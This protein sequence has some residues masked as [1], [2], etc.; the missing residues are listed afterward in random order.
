[1]FIS[2]QD[3][4]TKMTKND[5]MNEDAIS[6]VDQQEI[7][8]GYGYDS[9]T[10]S[11]LYD[12]D[13]LKD[14]DWDPT[15]HTNIPES[16]GGWTT[17]YGKKGTGEKRNTHILESTSAVMSRT[18]AHPTRLAAS[19]NAYLEDLGLLDDT[20]KF[21]PKKL[22]AAREKFG[23][24]RMAKNKS[25]LMESGIRGLYWDERKDKTTVREQVETTVRYEGKK[26]TV[27]TV[28]QKQMVHEHCPVLAV[29][30]KIRRI[31]SPYLEKGTAEYLSTVLHE[32][33]KE[34]ESVE[35][36]QIVG[37]DSCNKMSGVDGGTQ[38]LLKQKFGRPLQRIFCILHILE[39]VWKRFFKMVDGES[40]SPT[41]LTGT[42]GKTLNNP[43]LRFEDIKD[44]EPVQVDKEFFTLPERVV[45]GLSY[46][47]KICYHLMQAAIHGPAYFDKHPWLRTAALGKFHE[48]HWVTLLNALLRKFFSTIR[49]KAEKS[50]N[51]KS[52]VRFGVIVYGTA[53]FDALKH[54]SLVEAAP[55]FH[56]LVVSIREFD[57]FKGDQREK[58][59]KVVDWNSYW[60]HPENVLVAMQHDDREEVRRRAFTIVKDL[61]IRARRSTKV[62]QFQKIEVDWSVEH[63][64]DFLSCVDERMWTCPPVFLDVAE[65]VLRAGVTE[66][67]SA[68][69]FDLR[70][71]PNATRCVERAVQTNTLAAA[72]TQTD[73]H[74]EEV[75][76][77]LEF[78]REKMPDFRKKADWIPHKVD[79]V[80]H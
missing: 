68:D 44:F 50:A 19:I 46:D 74:R 32:I 39:T 35:K 9:L 21:G 30:P 67:P 76:A 69:V 48:A 78:S 15:E 31:K 41:S 20:T 4:N 55:V 51:L 10:R 8:S 26:S 6:V 33:C 14:L 37:S 54:G 75:L 45:N 47:Q 25:E 53:W 71:Y 16:E 7:E 56:R 42:V 22:F 70:G 1:M 34:Y 73:Q 66:G 79:R 43:N 18:L 38:A 23:K 59:A 27:T 80:L 13:D 77:N 62:R 64:Y 60:A 49:S 2:K 28:A 36:V 3:K 11:S 72:I 57:G 29:N 65:D 61:Q 58:M 12:N 5:P 63:Y 17:K 40:S 52:L 24:A